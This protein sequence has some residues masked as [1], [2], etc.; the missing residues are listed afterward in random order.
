MSSEIGGE[1]ELQR[2]RGELHLIQ[3]SAGGLQ[4]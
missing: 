2:L 4:G 1:L 3:G